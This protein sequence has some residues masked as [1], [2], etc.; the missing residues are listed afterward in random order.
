MLSRMN[1]SKARSVLSPSLDSPEALIG[2]LHGG[3]D[4]WAIQYID[5]CKTEEEAQH[6]LD[7]L[8][9]MIDYL[10]G[11]ILE[12]HDNVACWWM[13][14]PKGFVKAYAP[15]WRVQVFF[16][17]APDAQWLPDGSRRV[18]VLESQRTAMGIV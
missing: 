6:V 9:T 14:K 17:D 11:R 4:M 7:S 15:V 10:G 13:P 5:E 1:N 8:S 18:L 3:L 2:P 16:K 12:P